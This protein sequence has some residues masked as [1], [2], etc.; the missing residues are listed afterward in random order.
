MHEECE[1]RDTIC[2]WNIKKS[3]KLMEGVVNTYQVLASTSQLP[4][5]SGTA[6]GVPFN[7]G[8]IPT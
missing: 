5:L 7:N 1:T 3:S 8:E 4:I 2:V 6:L